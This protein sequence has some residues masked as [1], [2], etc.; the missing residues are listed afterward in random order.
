[1]SANRL[2]YPFYTAAFILMQEDRDSP[3]DRAI[4]DH[5]AEE[6]RNGGDL[7][8][9]RPPGRHSSR[10]QSR[11]SG[12]AQKHGYEEPEDDQ[13]GG[14]IRLDEGGNWATK[15]AGRGGFSTMRESD[16]GS[17]LY[18]REPR[19]QETSASKGWDLLD[20]A[21]A[22][23]QG[24]EFGEEE[25]PQAAKEANYDRKARARSMDT[26]TLLS[27]SRCVCMCVYVCVF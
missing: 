5:K 27:H 22:G 23:N 14:Q 1:M 26:T 6:E 20:K 4:R 24:S 19:K 7:Y 25:K 8:D 11:A 21:M 10:G 3:V 2:S 12:A 13:A 17:G 15:A 16:E 9:E 18:S